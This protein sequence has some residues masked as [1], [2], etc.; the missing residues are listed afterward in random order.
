MDKI[1]NTAASAGV[2]GYYTVGKT[3]SD[4][5]AENKKQDVFKQ[6]NADTTGVVA[7]EYG[8]YS[9]CQDGSFQAAA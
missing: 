9:S 5:V 6:E 4:V 8:T 2:W 1:W 7:F 3:N